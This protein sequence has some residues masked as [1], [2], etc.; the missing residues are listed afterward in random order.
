MKATHD[1]GSDYYQVIM[2]IVRACA[3]ESF[4]ELGIGCG[5]LS[6]MLRENC[7]QLEMITGVDI[8]DG[9]PPPEGVEWIRNKTTNDFFREDERTWDC[10]FVDADHMR[11]QATRDVISSLKVL[12]D[13]GLML[14]H[15]TYPPTIEAVNP[16]VCGDVFKTYLALAERTDLEV[17]TLPL[18]N[19]LT[20]VRQVGERR[21]WTFDA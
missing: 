2:Q 17:V 4:L 12:N 3:F 20:I 15:D 18:L 11:P 16:M 21:I 13:D 5:L 14:M 10:I 19:G 9:D 7:P 8:S 6:G 1:Q